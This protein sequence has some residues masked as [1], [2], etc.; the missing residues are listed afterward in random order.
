[1]TPTL[2]GSAPTGGRVQLAPIV[3]SL[4]QQQRLFWTAATARA[5][6]LRRGMRGWETPTNWPDAKSL[7]A[8]VSDAVGYVVDAVQRQ[9]LFWDTMRQAGN[10]FIEHEKRGCPPVLVFDYETIIDG[11]TLDR[12]VN[13]ALV[14]I[15]APEGYKAADP[16]LRPFVIIDPRAGHGAGIGGFKDDSEVGVALRGRHP[17]YFVVFYRDPVVGQTIPDVT[18]AEQHFLRGVAARHPDAPKPVVIGNCQGGWAAILLAATAPALVGPL[19]LNGAPLSYWAG[20]PGHGV[21]RYAGGLAGGSW[22]CDI[23]RRPRRRSVRRR[24][25]WPEFRVAIARQYLVP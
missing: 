1:M 9:T 10:G 19:V 13:Y 14:R 11:R 12:P 7:E 8:V 23:A 25:S 5:E 16:A 21:M 22:P 18:D 2:E 17:V 3:T 15:V 6:T 4:L 24:P 20:R